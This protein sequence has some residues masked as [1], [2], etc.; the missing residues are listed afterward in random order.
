MNHSSVVN[1]NSS[2][3]PNNICDVDPETPNRKSFSDLV[4]QAQEDIE[5]RNQ[6]YVSSDSDGKEEELSDKKENDRPSDMEVN[7]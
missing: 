7:I 2:F 1:M 3:D 6:Q 4:D 5:K